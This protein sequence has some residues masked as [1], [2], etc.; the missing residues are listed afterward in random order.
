[1]ARRDLEQGT[2]FA[3]YKM[4]PASIQKLIWFP[5]QIDALVRTDVDIAV[6]LSVPPDNN[7]MPGFVAAII[8][9]LGIG[10]FSLAGRGSVTEIA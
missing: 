2:M 10:V 6:Q 3:A 5:V 4:R 9:S 1:M 7:D 8:V